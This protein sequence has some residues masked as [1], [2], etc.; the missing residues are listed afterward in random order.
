M[1]R[2]DFLRRSSCGML[3]AGL[4]S[5][6]HA[7]SHAGGSR[8]AHR[9]DSVFDVRT[10]GATGDGKTIDTPSVNKAIEAAA[11]AGGGTI[12]FPAGTYACYTIRL[13]SHISLHLDAGATI[14]AAD[15][16]KEGTT[17][18]GYDPAGPPQPWESYQDFGHNHWPNSLIWG[19]GLEDVSIFGPG[20][21]RGKGL[22]RGEANEFPRAESPGVGNKAIALKNSRNV[23]LRDFSILMGGHFG[24][25]LTGVDNV[26]ID[27]LKI[28][29][30]R[31][32]IDI[33]CCRNVRVSNCA[34]NSP[35]DD[36]ICPKSSFALGYA[37]ATENVTISDCYVT[38]GYEFGTM[39]DG[40]WKRHTYSD[41]RKAVGRIKCG[42]ESNGGFKNITITN[43]IF[44]TCRGLALETADGALIEDITIS[45]LTMRN[46][47]HSP[48]FLRLESRMRGP[49][50]VAPGVLRRVLISNISS[51]GAVAEYP[52]IIAGIPGNRIEDIKISD[53]YLQQMGGGGSEWASLQPPTLPAGYPEASMFGTLPA[54]GFFLRHAKNLEFSNVEIAT[55]K[56]DARPAVWAEDVEGLD[57]F[58]LRIPKGT[59][60]FDLRNVRDFRSFG[61]AVLKDRSAESIDH[62]QW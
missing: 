58:R 20:L 3:V 33:D 54:S 40:T 14:L 42:T 62:E 43:C 37:R 49:A 25:L 60:A 51:S 39:L 47:V 19:E 35:W 34:V 1:F 13:K 50:G 26:L 45:N 32:G 21:I 5:D 15:V 17:T 22:S 27:G 52:S 31:D 12:F 48:L 56:A 2:R 44:D 53:V 16:P 36:A 30:N 59:A 55:V 8:D 7:Q 6:L 18:G 11:A 4:S 41:V 46:V 29:T 38:G 61:S 24:I 23:T 9:A 10:Y 28:D 57:L